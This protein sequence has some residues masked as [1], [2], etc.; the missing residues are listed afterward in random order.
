MLWWTIAATAIAVL[1]IIITIVLSLQLRKNKEPAWAHKTTTVIGLGADAPPEL[2][3]SFAGKLVNDVQQTTFIFFN[4]GRA[5]I[6]KADVTEPITI[7]FQRA[8]I[9]RDPVFKVSKEP[10]K[11]STKWVTTNEQ[12]HAIK[13]DFLYLDHEDGAVVDV[14]HT[15]T[16]KISC[17]GNIKGTKGIENIGSL[18]RESPELHVGWV[19]G[20]VFLTV[21]MVC[22]WVAS[23]YAPQI[24]TS[25]PEWFLG[26]VNGVAPLILSAFLGVLCGIAVNYMPKYI[27]CRKFPAWSRNVVRLAF[28]GKITEAKAYCMK[29]RRQNRIKNPKFYTLKNGKPAVQG[30]CPDCGTKVFRIG[31][32]ATDDLRVK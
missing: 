24:F 26:F 1:G 10:I 31:V 27:R 2:Q 30:V 16:E 7:Q 11:F 22:L 12:G 23:V 14:M 8:E 28:K 13:L 20:L 17:H 5:T 25:F 9:L 3:L 15:T 19:V 32:T 4:K 18:E 6:D 21:A 29:C